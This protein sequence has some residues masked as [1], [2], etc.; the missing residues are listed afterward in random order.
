MTIETRI[1][2]DDGNAVPAGHVGELWLRGP[3]VATGYWNQPETTAK[4]FRDGWF[5]TG[6][7]AMMDEDGF[8]YI[9]DRKKDMYISGGENV[10]PAEVEA[11][12]AELAQV[13][14]CAVVGVPD[15]RWGEVG[16]VY[17]IPVPGRS[18]TPEEV[19]A[20]CAQRL[21]RFKVPKSAVI[22]DILPRT[23]SGKVQKHL[24][25]TRAIQELA[26]L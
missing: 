15:E 7:A 1:V 20:H 26:V 16:R 2:G 17:V 21:A 19:I 4:A 22:T 12:I 13:G 10:Y 14:E 9:V 23:A 8:Y 6:D 18:I 11:A 25:K 3:C 5:I 24:L